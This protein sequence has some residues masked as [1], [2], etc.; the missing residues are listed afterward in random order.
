[1]STRYNYDPLGAGH[2][3]MNTA[4]PQHDAAHGKATAPAPR[5]QPFSASPGAAFPSAGK[6]KQSY[7]VSPDGRSRTWTTVGQDQPG[8]Q[9]PF[10]K[11]T[12]Q[13]TSPDG[14][15]TVRTL[16]IHWAITPSKDGKT[17]SVRYETNQDDRTYDKTGRELAPHHKKSF[18][19]S[20]QNDGSA[21]PFEEPLRCAWH[22]DT[23]RPDD[24]QAK[25]RRHPRQAGNKQTT[26]LDSATSDL[27]APQAGR[28]PGTHGRSA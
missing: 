14:I 24:E 10:L 18:K 15:T 23:H 5:N 19:G 3:P 25:A 17:R 16:D 9:H 2:L 20:F 8:A 28:H 4:G 13:F 22:H 6:P 7:C 26:R 11:R 12:F 1:M 21:L 27:R